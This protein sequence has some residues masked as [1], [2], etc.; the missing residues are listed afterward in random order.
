M[1]KALEIFFSL[2]LLILLSQTQTYAATY[3]T[4]EPHPDTCTITG[5][6]CDSNQTAFGTNL[7]VDFFADHDW[8]AGND[9]LHPVT[10]LPGS[11]I[12]SSGGITA[13]AS[14]PDLAAAGYC[15]GGGNHGFGFYISNVKVDNQPSFNPYVSHT[16]YMHI[17]GSSNSSNPLIG[18]PFSMTCSPVQQGGNC[19][20][21]QQCASSLT[22]QSG[23]CEPSS[24]S[25]PTPT[26]TTASTPMATLQLLVGLPGIGYN[27]S[28]PTNTTRTATIELYAPDVSNPGLPGTSPLTTSDIKLQY[29]TTGNSAGYFSA[30]STIT[31]PKVATANNQYQILIKMPQ[32]LYRLVVN[33]NAD[34][35]TNSST[36][37]TIPVNGTVA[38]TTPLL[39]EPGDLQTANGGANVLNLDDYTL[40][41]SCFQNASSCPTTADGIKVADL[42]DDGQV[43][44]IDFNLFVRSLADMKT[45]ASSHCTGLQCQGD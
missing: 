45:N 28:A 43:D 15:G 31:M 32:Y 30:T 38:I 42:N 13:T 4:A 3:G 44:L 22:C 41:Q 1:K 35:T 34:T 16:Y 11:S 2:F 24:A 27:G 29:Q 19:A 18:N 10:A 9:F 26:S 37:F 21:H 5:W 33:P 17:I 25:A 6:V 12:T 8:Q 20:Q 36:V 40:L 7:S 39:L 14:R 23:K